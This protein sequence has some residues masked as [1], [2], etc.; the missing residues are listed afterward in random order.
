MAHRE[1][2][3]LYYVY[4]LHLTPNHEVFGA[5]LALNGVAISDHH[6]LFSFFDRVVNTALFTRGLLTLKESGGIQWAGRSFDDRK[7]AVQDVINDMAS[8]WA[9]EH[10]VSTRLSAPKLEVKADATRYFECNENPEVFLGATMTIP[11]VFVTRQQTGIPGLGA[12]TQHVAKH[13]AEIEGWQAQVRENKKEINKLK[14]QDKGVSTG[15][16]YFF[17]CVSVVLITWFWTGKRVYEKCFDIVVG[18]R[19]SLQRELNDVGDQRLY[20]YNELQKQKEEYE[21]LS[22]EYKYM[23]QNASWWRSGDNHILNKYNE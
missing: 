19:D 23:R 22:E 17:F 12:W 2:A 1:G 5:G 7:S 15:W 14:S 16:F 9:A 20:Y 18:Q 21:R 13:K 4:L 10:P 3:L 8:F 11:W 6:A